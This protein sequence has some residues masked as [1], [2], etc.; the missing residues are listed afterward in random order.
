MTFIPN[1][2]PPPKL[3]AELQP[4]EEWM[5]RL[6]DTVRRVYLNQQ[7]TNAGIG[8]ASSECCWFPLALGSVT[9]LAGVEVHLGSV[10]EAPSLVLHL[11]SIAS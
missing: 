7:I 2:P 10:T 5:R 8:G 1:F 4:V 3:T 9:E 11:G 6:N